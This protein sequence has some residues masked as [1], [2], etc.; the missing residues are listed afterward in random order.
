MGGFKSSISEEV[1][2][3]SEKGVNFAADSDINFAVSDL[4]I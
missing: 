2:T 3:I 1:S 4:K